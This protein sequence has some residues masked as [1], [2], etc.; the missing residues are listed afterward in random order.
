MHPEHMK[1]LKGHYGVEPPSK[2]DQPLN[3]ELFAYNDRGMKDSVGKFA[4]DA[5]VVRA[6]LD[7]FLRDIIAE[8]FKEMKLDAVIETV[9]QRRIEVAAKAVS[10]GLE[11]TM[12]TKAREMMSQRLADAI[13]AVPLQVDVSIRP[14]A[15]NP[16]T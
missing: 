1:V 10:Q 9:V 4:V 2:S 7:E 12:A 16:G 14:G 3:V 5:E 15:V 6:K 11:A 13:S 8:R